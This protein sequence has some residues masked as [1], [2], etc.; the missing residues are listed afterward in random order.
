MLQVIRAM[1]KRQAPATVPAFVD[2]IP[3]HKGFAVVY[4]VGGKTARE[5]VFPTLE[6]AR[7][8]AREQRAESA[9]FVRH[10]MRSGWKTCIKR[11]VF[12]R[13]LENGRVSA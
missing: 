5:S 7:N 8:A 12:I 9:D 6:E 10:L 11:H 1:F 3:P 13:N 4:K 2:D